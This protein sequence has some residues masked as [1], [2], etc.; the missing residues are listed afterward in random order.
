MSA[1]RIVVSFGQEKLEMDNYNRF[2]LKVRDVGKRQGAIGGMSLGFF[3]FVI[4]FCYA[5]SFIMG[6]VWI[7][8]KFWNHAED[9]YYTAG[10]VMAVF[11]GVLIGLFALGGAGPA[12]NAV[13]LAK[14]AGKTA[15]EVID[16]VSPI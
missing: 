16:R 11:F 5:Y 1:I 13:S 6:C 2:L 10:D 15:Y 7:D 9:R 12:G 4:Y 14:A 8:E 3:F